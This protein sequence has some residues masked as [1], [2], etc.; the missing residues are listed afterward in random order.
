MLSGAFRQTGAFGALE[1][2]FRMKYDILTLPGS[3]R[4]RKGENMKDK[5][6]EMLRRLSQAYADTKSALHYQNPYE[7]LTA[8]ILAAQCTDKRVNIIT[9]DFFT[10]FPNA[11]ALAKG[12]TQEVEALIRTCG[13][14]KA[15][16]KNLLACAR[17]LVS[18]YG[19]EVPRS[20]EEL[21]TLAGVGRKTASVVLAYAFGIPA[22]AVDTHVGRVANRL[23]LANSKNP[24]IIEKQLCALI[25]K[26][27]WADAHHWLI[28]HG[29][30]VCHAQRPE[31]GAC[32]VAD[33]C[34]SA[35]KVPGKKEKGK[36]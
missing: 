1:I 13:L 3:G 24:V 31:C 36:K 7:L 5:R 22:M 30:R 6:E 17:R 4:W 8:T 12:E 29:R 23:G 16:A 32:V 2:I 26:E 28:W 27:D 33:L 34:P 35:F 9:K 15:K 14:Y 21:T 18:E 11:R 25:P 10:R 19:G 20:M